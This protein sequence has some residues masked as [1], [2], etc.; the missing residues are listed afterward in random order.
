[1]HHT[2]T[3]DNDHR[4][5]VRRKIMVVDNLDEGRR[6]LSSWLARRGYAVVEAGGG[7]EA[8]ELARREVPDLILMD[9]KMPGLDG[10]G[11]AE[12]IRRHEYL[13]RVPIVAVSGDGTEYAKSRAGEAG[14]CAYLTK[15]VETEELVELLGRYLP[16][17]SGPVH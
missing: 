10:F 15:P 3:Q 5:D 14:F 1:M 7:R 9:I 6:L 13:S 8:V 11:A 4:D 16:P 2:G 17:A 12:G